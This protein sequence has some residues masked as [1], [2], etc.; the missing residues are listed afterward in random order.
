MS[1]ILTVNAKNP[2]KIAIE[3]AITVIKAGGVIVYPTDTLY[4]LGANALDSKAVL[5]V[6]EVKN[7]PLS[8][9]LPV[10]V[11]G[12][13][14]A[15]ELAFITEAA[16]RLIKAFWP[17]SLTIILKRRPLVPLEVTGGS[18]GIGLR[19]PNHVVPLT[20]SRMSGLPLTATSANKHG[21]SD[22][23]KMSDALNQLTE[24]V[25]LFLDGGTAE[26]GVSS[27]VLDL[28]GQHP[29]IVR[30]GPIRREDMEPIIGHLENGR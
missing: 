3:K 23:V 24:G 11:S 10:I 29:I 14:M 20:I 26:L 1:R 25:D 30:K 13:E 8:Q 16:E 27:T 4:G 15:N 9:A 5:K 22:P 7:R 2:E 19:A 21:G 18:N 12:I 17:G 6:F 28:T